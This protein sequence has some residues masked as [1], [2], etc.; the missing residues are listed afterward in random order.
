MIRRNA[1]RASALFV[2][3]WAESPATVGA[4]CPSSPR[5]ARRIA[6]AVPDG[7]G[8]V[9]ELGGGT[10]VVTQALLDHRVARERLVVVE[11]SPAFVRHLRARF[12]DVSIVQGDAMWLDQLFPADARIDA[13]V[14]CL[15][16]RSLPRRDVTIIVDQCHR[17]LACNGAMIQFT[18][19]LRPPGRNPLG[20][21]GLVASG[22]ISRLPGLSRCA[23]LRTK[24]DQGNIARRPQLRLSCTLHR[25]PTRFRSLVRFSQDFDGFFQ[26]VK[27]DRETHHQIDDGI[28]SQQN[29]PT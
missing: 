15:P 10:G 13:I 9:V 20:H 24:D 27:A 17:I 28:A 8:L 23:G 19:D 7:D 4:L 16:V 22:G 18:Y 21:M 3:E 29:Y 5:L 12:A 2:R 1:W 26:Y 6:S 14:S 11:R 25:R